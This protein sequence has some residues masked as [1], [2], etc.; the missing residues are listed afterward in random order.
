LPEETFAEKDARFF[1]YGSGWAHEC[2]LLNA[3]V[4]LNT[5]S[6]EEIPK[7]RAKQ[8][9]ERE[10]KFDKWIFVKTPEIL[11][12]AIGLSH[13][14]IST[15]IP[16]F[17]EFAAKVKS[18]APQVIRGNVEEENL[19]LAEIQEAIDFMRV[20]FQFEKDPEEFRM[21]KW[22]KDEGFTI[23]SKM[24]RNSFRVEFSLEAFTRLQKE[25]KEKVAVL[26]EALSWHEKRRG[27]YE[28]E[29]AQR[30]KNELAEVARITAELRR[31][32]KEAEL[33]RDVIAKAV[34]KCLAS[35]LTD[36][37]AAQDFVAARRRFQELSGEHRA[38]TKQLA[39]VNVS[40]RKLSGIPDFPLEAT[41]RSIDERE[42]WRRMDK[43]ARLGDSGFLKKGD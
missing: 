3:T 24:H 36:Q 29:L 14:L 16:T 28:A 43:L 35:K 2:S 34:K 12:W 26:I 9:R 27:I 19:R 30:G 6:D 18:L 11:N 31:V 15:P 40:G 7:E 22:Q 42:D 4:D 25:I 17:E 21:E 10:A 5:I 32:I 20:E 8:A 33:Q 37:A 39:A 41:P 23:G 1:A 13:G 38:L